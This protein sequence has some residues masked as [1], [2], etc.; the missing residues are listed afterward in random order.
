[1]LSYPDTYYAATAE[2]PPA[3]PPLMGDVKAEIVVI[4]GG[5][6]GTSAA[7]TLAE[8]GAKRGAARGRA[9]R[10]RRL[11]P[12]RRPDPLRLPL[13]AGTPGARNRR[14]AGARSLAAW[15]ED[16]KALVRERARKHEIECA[17]TDGLLIGRAPPRAA[18]RL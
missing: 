3:R 10:L 9:H 14:R 16:A 4:G 12:Q 6:T 17:L 11:G 18:R 8:A 15:R 2:T 1:M 13:G 5:F 7:L